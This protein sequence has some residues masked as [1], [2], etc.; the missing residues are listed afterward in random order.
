MK[1]LYNLIDASSG[2]AD[3]VNRVQSFVWSLPLDNTFTA[4]V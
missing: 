2:F 4:S 1:L 3:L